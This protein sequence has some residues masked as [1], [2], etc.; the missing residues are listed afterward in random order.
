[1]GKH[2]AGI[3]FGVE[4]AVVRIRMYNSN[5]HYSFYEHPAGFKLC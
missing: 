5:S 2:D 3:L 1:M 4:I